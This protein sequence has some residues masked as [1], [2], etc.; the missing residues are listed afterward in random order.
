MIQIFV[1]LKVKDFD[2]MAQFENEAAARLKALSSTEGPILDAGCGT[3]MS[4]RALHAA[5]FQAR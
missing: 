2:L 1:K 4:G 5:G 3:G